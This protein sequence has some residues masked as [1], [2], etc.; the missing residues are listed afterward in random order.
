MFLPGLVHASVFAHGT[1]TGFT[2]RDACT[3]AH[4]VL[5][6][7]RALAAVAA[8]PVLAL[9]P[10]SVSGGCLNHLRG[11]CPEEGV[12]IPFLDLL[13]GFLADLLVLIAFCVH[14]A[15][16]IAVLAGY[17]SSK[18]NAVQLQTLGF[19]TVA[20]FVLFLHS[21]GHQRTEGQGCTE[22]GST[23]RAI[24]GSRGGFGGIDGCCH[25]RG[26]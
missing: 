10:L 6:I 15:Y 22:V 17:L 14:A 1:A 16:A 11:L 23:Q 12:G 9:A 25:G 4:A 3:I 7:A 19:F 5:V 26:G 13:D 21:S 24:H 18:A 8:S 2:T 20:R